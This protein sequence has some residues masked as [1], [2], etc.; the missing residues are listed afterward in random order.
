[1]ADPMCS[2]WTFP[3]LVRLDENSFRQIKLKIIVS[4]FDA[5]KSSPPPPHLPQKRK[6]ERKEKNSLQ[7]SLSIFV[8]QAGVAKLN[9]AAEHVADLKHKAA[10]QS[11]LLAEKQAEA[12]SALKQ[13]TT[14]MEVRGRKRFCTNFNKMQCL[15]FQVLQMDL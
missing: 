10:S 13:I 11:A 8:L 6:K 2:T 1:M 15:G 3:W 5:A 12:D 7:F 14:A 9:Q 4:A